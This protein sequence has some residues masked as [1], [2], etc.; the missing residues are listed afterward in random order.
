MEAVKILQIVGFKNSGKTTLMNRLIERAQTSGRKVSA[1]KHHG[2]SGIPELP[3]KGTDSTQFLASGAAS[4][5]V[6]GGGLVQLHLEEPE[7]DLEKFIRFSLLANPDLIL[8]EGFKGAGYPKI[9]LV[10]SQEDWRELGALSNIQLVIVHDGVKL[11]NTATVDAGNIEAIARFFT[12]WM[13]GEVDES[14]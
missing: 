6:Y 12:E 4:S 7:A 14:I 11:E 10:R 2:H 3:P 5:L 1:I 13:E 8:I 9:V